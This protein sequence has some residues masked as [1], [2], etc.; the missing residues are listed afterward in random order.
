MKIDPRFVN[1]EDLDD[2]DKELDS[3]L[4]EIIRKEKRLK[5]DK[6]ANKKNKHF[7]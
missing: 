7:N 5:Q 6:I 4:D 1:F 2:F 3:T